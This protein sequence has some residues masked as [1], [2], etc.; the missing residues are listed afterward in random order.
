[1]F[2]GTAGVFTLIAALGLEDLVFHEALFRVNPSFSQMRATSR[3][4]GRVSPFKVLNFSSAPTVTRRPS[5]AL[6]SPRP[7][8]SRELNDRVADRI[9]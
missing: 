4:S 1:M 9:T 6:P 7:W 2:Y 3:L 5:N 8:R